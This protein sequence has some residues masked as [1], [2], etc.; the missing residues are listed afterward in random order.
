MIF[1]NSFDLLFPKYL[2]TA[3]FLKKYMFFAR[4]IVVFL[5]TV[6]YYILYSR[7]ILHPN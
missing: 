5:V 1:E 6:I 4:D 2:H 7:K 3:K